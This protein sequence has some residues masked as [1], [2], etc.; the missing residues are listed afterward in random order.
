MTSSYDA[1]HVAAV[2]RQ[3]PRRPGEG[4][5]AFVQRICVLS[6]LITPEETAGPPAGG[7]SSAGEVLEEEPEPWFQK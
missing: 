6:G 1:S 7:W 4:A 5:L 3:N 2:V